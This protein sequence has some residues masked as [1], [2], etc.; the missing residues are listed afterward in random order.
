MTRKEAREQAF[1]LIFE[2][3]ISKL[4]TADI[5][6][7]A[8]EARDVITNDFS[9]TLFEGVFAHLEEIDG[10]I[11]ARLQ[12]WR[13]ERLSKVV[14]ALLRLCVFELRYLED[15]PASVSINEAVE[16]CKKY[17]TEEDTAYLNGVLGSIA[18][19]AEQK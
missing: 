8:A 17:A 13:P 12:G 3:E 19:A 11:A 14:L 9:L 15:V 18:R 4:D 6:A 7:N 10:Q 1:V 2:K 5:L 16:L